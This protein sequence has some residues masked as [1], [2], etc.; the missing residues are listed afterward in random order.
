MKQDG[1]MR[2]LFIIAVPAFVL[3][4]FSTDHLVAADEEVIAAIGFGSNDGWAILYGTRCRYYGIPAGPGKRI[5]DDEIS[6]CC[7]Y[8]RC[9]GFF[10]LQCARHCG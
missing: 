5:P 3:T 2:T 7:K 1:V 4:A 10:L 6:L 9:Y 8:V